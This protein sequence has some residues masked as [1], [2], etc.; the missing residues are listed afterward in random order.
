M[1]GRRWRDGFVEPTELCGTKFWDF[2]LYGVKEQNPKR[3]VGL[4]YNSTS[5]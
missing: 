5:C 4:V 2:R 3:T 1:T